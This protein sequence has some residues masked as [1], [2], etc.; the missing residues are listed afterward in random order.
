MKPTQWITTSPVR[1]PPVGPSPPVEVPPR[2]AMISLVH[3]VM[4]GMSR[5]PFWV[6]ETA[7]HYRLVAFHTMA[8]GGGGL[9][10]FSWRSPRFGAE[11]SRNGY[12]RHGQFSPRF[13]ESQKIAADL[14]TLAR[15]MSATAS[16]GFFSSARPAE[17]LRATTATAFGHYADGHQA[18]TIQGH[19]AGQAIYLGF[20]P[21]V[22]FWHALIDWLQT[23]G[24]VSPLLT[25]P[26]GVEVTRRAGPGADVRFVLNHTFAPATVSLPHPYRDLLTGRDLSGEVQIPPQSTL[27]MQSH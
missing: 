12:E 4:R 23:S 2:S 9:S 17:H 13:H 6:M 1:K 8:H 22:A 26:P 11:Q 3:D 15:K 16:H 20:S 25:T 7:G 24:A 19:G 21:D 14:R 27:V 18:C 5:D 10:T